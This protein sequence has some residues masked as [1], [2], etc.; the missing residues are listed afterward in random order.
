[1]RVVVRAREVVFS[2]FF[3]NDFQPWVTDIVVFSQLIFANIFFLF[4]TPKV[5]FHSLRFLLS[6]LVLQKL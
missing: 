2:L 4:F 6:L 1:M 3:S 5:P